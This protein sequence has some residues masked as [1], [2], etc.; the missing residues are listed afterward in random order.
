MKNLIGNSL[1]IWN[2]T[3]SK[4]ILAWVLASVISSTSVNAWIILNERFSEE[5]LESCDFNNDWVI[6]WKSD[7]KAW[8]VTK[9][10]SKKEIKCMLRVEGELLDSELQKLEKI[11]KLL[12]VN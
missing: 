4:T 5:I 3:I 6:N 2:T 10:E 7:Y 11:K 1:N 9:Q 8:L 12:D